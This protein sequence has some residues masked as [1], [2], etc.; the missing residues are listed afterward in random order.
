MNPHLVYYTM[1]HLLE[2]LKWKICWRFGLDIWN[3]FSTQL[4]FSLFYKFIF[5]VLQKKKVSYTLYQTS[6][7][8]TWILLLQRFGCA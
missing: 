2:Y 3:K 7:L 4:S 5:S 6:P 8:Q 1:V